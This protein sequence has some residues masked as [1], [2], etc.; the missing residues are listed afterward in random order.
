MSGRYMAL[1]P[2]LNTQDSFLGCVY[3]LQSIASPNKKANFANCCSFSKVN[4]SPLIMDNSIL[5][6]WADINC[7][8]STGSLDRLEKCYMRQILHIIRAHHTN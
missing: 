7:A 2:N 5:S 3:D 8:L 6:P 4:S 1:S